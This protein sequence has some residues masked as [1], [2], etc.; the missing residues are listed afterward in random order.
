MFDLALDAEQEGVLLTQ[1]HV[2]NAVLLQIAEGPIHLFE[3][4]FVEGGLFNLHH[5][6]LAILR[7]RG[8][9]VGEY[10]GLGI[11]LGAGLAQ[12]NQYRILSDGRQHGGLSVTGLE[13]VHCIDY[14]LA[15]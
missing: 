11:Q 5:E 6:V 14:R 10:G 7:L 9:N 12:T 15:V 13:A 2:V 3:C 1:T 4:D 8:R